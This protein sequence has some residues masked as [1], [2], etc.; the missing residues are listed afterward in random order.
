MSRSDFGRKP[1]LLL[2]R[3]KLRDATSNTVSTV[4][5][6]VPVLILRDHIL[7][8]FRYLPHLNVNQTSLKVLEKFDDCGFTER[9]ALLNCTNG[10]NERGAVM[11]ANGRYRL[12]SSFKNFLA[13]LISTMYGAEFDMKSKSGSRTLPTPSI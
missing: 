12:P 5:P 7:V 4:L 1:F 10:Q 11:V 13:P 8:P 6:V 3:L 2:N 9:K